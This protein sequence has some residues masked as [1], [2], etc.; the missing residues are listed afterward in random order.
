MRLEAVIVCK[1]YSDFLAETLPLNLQHFDDVVVVTHH[2]DKKTQKIC[3][4]NS[5][6]CIQTAIFHENGS[7]FNKGAGINVGLD[8]SPR[9]DWH[10]HLDADI[11]LPH[12]FRRMLDKHQLNPKNIYG[13]DRVNVYGWEAWQK[14]KP[15]LT[16]HYLDRWFID[17][18]FCH[19]ETVPEGTR[20][21]ARVIHMEY[22]WIPIGFFQ[23]WHSSQPHRYNYKRG[24]AAGTDVMFPAQWPRENRILLPE[25]VCYHLDSEPTHQ[26]GTNWKG[27]KSREFGP[28]GK[29]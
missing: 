8:N 9:K 21:G 11:V 25:V 13:A 17:P 2:D 28:R 20:F 26:I 10:I 16:P 22:G 14:L 23:L 24:A 4:R 7:S 27:R 29:L 3:A 6:D 15:K 18:G 19:S 12:G 5:V 1:D